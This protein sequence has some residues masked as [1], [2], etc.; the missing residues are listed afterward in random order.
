MHN[1]LAAASARDVSAR[2]ELR[3]LWRLREA[4]KKKQRSGS[5]EVVNKAIRTIRSKRLKNRR[6]S[7]A[8]LITAAGPAAAKLHWQ[9]LAENTG[10]LGAPTS[11]PCKLLDRLNDSSGQLISLER[12]EIISKI[13][14]YRESVSKTRADFSPA[15]LASINADLLALSQI[16]SQ[17]LGLDPAS[18]AA[19]SAV[20]PSSV[21]CGQ[22]QA[23][24]A[25]DRL[26]AGVSIRKHGEAR[27]KFPAACALLEADLTIEELALVLSELKDKGSGIDGV[28]AAGLAFLK[29]ETQQW[30]LGQLNE[31]WRRGMTPADWAEIRVVLLYKGKG[32]DPYCPDNY[33]GLGIGAVLEKVLSLMMMKRLESFL[34]STSALHPAQ[35]GFRPQRGPPE[36]TFTL[37]EAV[38][39]ALRARGVSPAFLCFIDIERAYDSVQHAKLWA[40]CIEMGIGGR[41]LSTLQAMHSGKKA[42]L[43]V[44]GEL[45]G[46]Q[47]IE[48]GVLQGNPLSPLLFN[49]YI[50]AL[51]RRIDEVA[52]GCN[53]AAGVSLPRVRADLRGPLVPESERTSLDMLY[54]LFF[55]DDGVLIARDR[56][57]LQLM[58]DAVVAELG[59]IC[60]LLNAKKTKVLIVPPLTATEAQYEAIKLEVSDAGGFTARGQ[61]VTIVDEFLYLG[62]M[63]WWRWNWKR[64]CEHALGRAKRVLYLLRRSGF[65]HQGAAMAHQLKYASSVVGSHIDYI[66]ALAGVEGYRA[67]IAAF[68]KLS[69][70]LLRVISC[71]PPSTSGP[72]LQS[73]FGVWDPQT[74]LRMLQLRFFCKITCMPSESTHV[75]ALCLSFSLGVAHEASS[76][77]DFGSS[78]LR[79]WAAHVVFDF[80]TFEKGLGGQQL[81]S[82]GDILHPVPKLVSLER[83]DAAGTWMPVTPTTPDDAA[84]PLQQLRVRSIKR[85]AFGVDYA[86]GQRVFEWYL[87]AG[88]TIHRALHSWSVP[89]RRAV[90]VSLRWLGNVYRNRVVFADFVAEWTGPDNALRDF[91]PL[92]SASY[93]EPFVF[94]IHVEEARRLLHARVGK[95][96]EEVGF[97]RIPR[98]PLKRLENPAERA[99]YLC[100]AASWMPETLSHLLLHCPHADM[101]KLRVSVREALTAIAVAAVGVPDC[102]PA[103]DFSSDVQLYTVLML[104]TSVGI[105]RDPAALNGLLVQHPLPGAAAAAVSLAD[106]RR[107]H[108]LRLD[109]AAMRSAALWVAFLTGCWRTQLAEALATIVG[110]KEGGRLVRVVSAHSLHVYSARRRLL[111]GVP[112]FAERPRDPAPVAR[113]R[114]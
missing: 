12:D 85:G 72:A 15:V 83:L 102:P 51:I 18:S 46:S 113:S 71:T 42:V 114:L 68:A 81:L 94:L 25:A 36:Q 33:R 63:L 23:V 89:L 104:C 4:I 47:D 65:Q 101:V 7:R 50:D 110:A 97:R 49:I 34:T 91:S 26:A 21:W 69:A 11:A 78:N 109:A 27:Q 93:V 24:S 3:G 58:I 92:K 73:M 9:L 95:W 44:N 108:E 10:D 19:R 28:S 70:D 86:T 30:L 29:S 62:V 74:R 52:S 13:L 56:A 14:E 96:G 66:S 8:H 32:S 80:C 76:A 60:L 38:R 106:R 75:R 84:L 40:R 16:N 79:A 31:V 57:T 54:S 88:T 103:P 53:A 112:D 35:G 107:D 39:A 22:K 99:C 55:A 90:Y 1:G 87:P 77:S 2:A 43:D 17:L 48:T 100:P 82:A 45:I 64:A 67:E 41:F 6:L 98:G 20:D 5:L 111:R 61:S 37:S 105:V 59:E